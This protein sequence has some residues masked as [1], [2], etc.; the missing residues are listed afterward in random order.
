MYI[1]ASD[2]DHVFQIL[3]L[4]ENLNSCQEKGGKI[5][6]INYANL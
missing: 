4:E 5:G 3:L 2:R 1:Y 6:R